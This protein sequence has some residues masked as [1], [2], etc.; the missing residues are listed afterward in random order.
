MKNGCNGHRCFFCRCDPREHKRSYAILG[1]LDVFSISSVCLGIRG[2]QLVS[3]FKYP[4]LFSILLDICFAPAPTVLEH[5]EKGSWRY[6]YGHIFCQPWEWEGNPE[7]EQKYSWDGVVARVL[8]ES[9]SK[10]STNLRGW[11][12]KSFIVTKLLRAGSGSNCC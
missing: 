10:S 6:I 7:N 3:T 1:S 5:G 4:S 8:S 9:T 12:V 2:V 11:Q